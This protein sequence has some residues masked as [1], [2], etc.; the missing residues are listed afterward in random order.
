MN[1]KLFKVRKLG[2][3]FV[4]YVDLQSWLVGVTW[5]LGQCQVHVGPLSLMILQ[6]DPINYPF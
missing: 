2:L 1:K 4:S 6:D 5:F 3:I